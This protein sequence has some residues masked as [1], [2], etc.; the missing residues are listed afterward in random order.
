MTG[1]SV[2]MSENY[3]VSIIIPFYNTEP[4]L[5]ECLDSVAGQTYG[6]I[7]IILVDD[8]STD[9][10]ARICEAYCEKDSR[11]VLLS[12]KN[13]GQAAARNLALDNVRGDYV[14]FSDSDDYLRR[15]AVETLISSVR[16][17]KADLTVF[18]IS[19]VS[20]S[21]VIENPRSGRTYDSSEKAMTAFLKGEDIT[22]VLCDKLYSSALFSSIR[23]PDLRKNE[24]RYIMPDLIDKCSVVRT[25]PECLYYIRTRAGSVERGSFSKRNLCFIECESHIKEFISERYPQLSEYVKFYRANAVSNVASK[26]LTNRSLKTHGE[27]F[28]ELYG[29]F[30]DEYSRESKETGDGKGCGRLTGVSKD[31]LDKSRSGLIMKYYLKG[32]NAGLK[33]FIKSVLNK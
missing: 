33:S 10:S 17:S 26:I 27:L 2:F 18:G 7:E 13:K 29:R 24:D 11:F 16:E 22:G 23:F 8:G 4:Y 14:I 6:N 32:Y 30:F 31:F 3:L 19:T 21:R 28:D 9:G 20:G 1:V 12:Q 15:D 25:V 5:K